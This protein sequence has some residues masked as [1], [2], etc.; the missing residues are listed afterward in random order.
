MIQRMTARALLLVAACACSIFEPH[1]RERDLREV[2][3]HR[4]QWQA[5][6]IH[7]YAFEYSRAC[8]CPPDLTNRVRIDVRG[9]TI[10]RVT[11]AQTGAD[12][13]HLQYARW[14]TVDSLFAGARR[15][16]SSGDWKYEIEY[17]PTLGY[18]RRLSGDIPNAVDDEFVETVHSFMRNP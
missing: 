16:I 8:F 4:D 7:S 3:R 10:F 1:G 11:N 14:P 17:D 5:Q 13:T 18:V 12:V 15:T 2:D 6:Q 9:D